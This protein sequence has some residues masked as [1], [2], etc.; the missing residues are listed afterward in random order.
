VADDRGHRVVDG[1]DLTVRAGEVLGIAGVQGNG[2]TELVEAVM[3]LRPVA[4]GDLRLNGPPLVGRHPKDIQPMRVGYIPE[5]RSVGGLV[6][7]FTVAENLVLNMYDTEPYGSRWTI[8]LDTIA[9]SAA[10]R[11]ERF[12]I[13]TTSVHARTATLSGGNQQKVI[14]AREF[15]RP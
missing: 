3:G 2:Q 11:A 4:G 8:R 9:S 14:V 13:R 12:D 6:K 7:D 15:T 10:E 1:V 5:D